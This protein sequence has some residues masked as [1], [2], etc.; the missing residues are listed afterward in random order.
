MSKNTSD[1]TRT[2]SFQAVLASMR[3]EFVAY[4]EA[5]FDEVISCYES[6]I[7]KVLVATLMTHHWEWGNLHNDPSVTDV[8]RRV[9]IAYDPTRGH[10]S[11]LDPPHLFVNGDAL[12]LTQ[13][14][15]KLPERSIRADFAF[16]DT[17]TASRVIVELDGHDWHERTPEQAQADKSRDRA[18]Q[19]LGWAA[20]RFTGRE[21]LRAPLQCQ[22]EISAML[23]AERERQR[24]QASGDAKS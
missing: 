14:S 1:A 6:P 4:A 11:P 22:F 7:E 3:S 20:L 12:C 10:A 16:I 19:R 5:T 18:L 2:P 8:L 17:Q 13:A 15:L 23:F 24:L 9:G 21:V